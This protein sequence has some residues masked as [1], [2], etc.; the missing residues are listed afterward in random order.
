VDRKVPLWVGLEG[1]TATIRLPDGRH[2]TVLIQGSGFGPVQIS[3]YG[4]SPS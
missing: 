1:D 3:G 2:A 4:P